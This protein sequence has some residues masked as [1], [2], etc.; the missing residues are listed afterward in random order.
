MS[1]LIDFM[2]EALGYLY[3][4]V[5]LVAGGVLFSLA[6]LIPCVLVIFLIWLAVSMGHRRAQRA[7]CFIDVLEI[8]LKQGRTLPQAVQSLAEFRVTEMGVYFHLM[9]A[10]LERGLRLSEALLEVP[11]FLPRHIGAMLRVGEELGDVARVL[12]VCR[13]TLQ[14]GASSTQKNINTLIVLL[15]VSPV[16]PVL[17]WL[18]QLTVFPKFQLLLQDMTDTGASVPAVSFPAATFQWSLILA[19]VILVLWVL[20]FLATCFQGLGTWLLRTIFPAWSQMA[21]A[22][23]LAIPWRRRRIQRDFSM[24]LGLLLDAGVPEAKALRLAAAGT[25]NRRFL[26]RAE[27]AVKDLQDG[28]KLPEAVRWLD[29]H[30]EFQWRLQNAC[31]APSRFVTALAGW[32]EALEARAFQQEQMCSQAFTTGFVLLNGLMVGLAT[33]GIFRTLAG[34]TTLAL[35]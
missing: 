20:F 33:F 35:W 4:H 21:D 10:W 1:D 9:A 27:R 29:R 28:V 32:Q 16:A 18:L 11:R 15:F 12:P 13:A 5:L 22:I 3:G 31:H 23:S 24:L 30:G 26:G 8:G 25:G 6:G 2:L 34:I 19:N 14:S 7:R 17:L